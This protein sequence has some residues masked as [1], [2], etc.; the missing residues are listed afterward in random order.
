MVTSWNG[1]MRRNRSIGS[2]SVR[3]LIPIIWHV[4]NKFQIIQH[5]KNK[6]Q[7]IR[8]VNNKELRTLHMSYANSYKKFI[9]L[10]SGKLEFI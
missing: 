4:R 6:I 8:H 1:K 10:S 7:I 9:N 3:V 2:I 5:V